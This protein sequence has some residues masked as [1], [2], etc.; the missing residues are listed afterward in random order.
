ME[1]LKSILKI[2]LISYVVYTTVRDKLQVIYLLF[3]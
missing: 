3:T 2:G 1:L